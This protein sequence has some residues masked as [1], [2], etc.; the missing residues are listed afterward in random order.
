M[1]TDATSS[2]DDEIARLTQ[3]R[4]EARERVASLRE[5]LADL[6]PGDEADRAAIMTQAL[7]QDAIADQLHQR[8]E[9]LTAQQ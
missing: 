2:R 1:T 5:Q 3:H 8:L 9:S 6:G 7:E 4:D